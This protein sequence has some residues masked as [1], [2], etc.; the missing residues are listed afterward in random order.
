MTN[1][2]LLNCEPRFGPST[3]TIKRNPKKYR[4]ER[5][6]KVDAVRQADRVEEIFDEVVVRDT[7][8]AKRA[9]CSAIRENP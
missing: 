3:R 5:K 9:P 7:P 1:P 8:D 4:L 6:R 2:F